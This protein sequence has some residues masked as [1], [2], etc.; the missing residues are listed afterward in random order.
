MKPAGIL[1]IYLFVTCTFTNCY[2]Q[3][4]MEDVGTILKN[5]RDEARKENKNV[6]VIF[7]ASWCV[8]CHRMDSA[9]NDKNIQPFF[10]K[11]YVIKHLTV[12]ER[13]DKKYLENPGAKELLTKYH[14]DAQGIPY[15]FIIDPNGKFLADS[16]V[17]GEDG[18]IIGNSV[19]CPAK[20]DEVA[21]FMKV[22]RRT[23]SLNEEELA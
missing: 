19:G 7:H 11:N 12:D 6:F 16:R 17:H 10:N 1:I 3:T 22:I 15:W 23:Y 14:G 9:M 21:Y 20:P 5:A 18:K 4:K 2:S 13:D 8:W